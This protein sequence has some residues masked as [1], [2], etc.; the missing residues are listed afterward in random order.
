MLS[1]TRNQGTSARSAN[2]SV[3]SKNTQ[4][5]ANP[6]SLAYLNCSPTQCETFGTSKRIRKQSIREQRQALSDVAPNPA[7]YLQLPSTTSHPIDPYDA[8]WHILNVT[9]QP[10]ISHFTIVLTLSSVQQMN[11]A[12]RN[13]LH[14]LHHNCFHPQ[15]GR[16]SDYTVARRWCLVQRSMSIGMM[17]DCIGTKSQ[18]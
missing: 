10:A 16:Y 14:L 3:I 8:S 17:K 15:M 18:E 13:R 11:S 4:K 12:D 9:R 5:K 1:A 6:L 2:G 7:T